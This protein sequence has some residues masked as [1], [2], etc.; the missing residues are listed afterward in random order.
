[1]AAVNDKYVVVGQPDGFTDDNVVRSRVFKKTFENFGTVNDG[2]K[3][4]L[5]TNYAVAKFPAGFVPRSI[6]VN[7]IEKDDGGASN[8]NASLA[9]YIAKN[10]TDLSDA[11]LGTSIGSVGLNAVGQTVK[12]DALTTTA[13]GSGTLTYTTTRALEPFVTSKNDY[14]VVTPSRADSGTG[15]VDAKFEVVVLGDWPELTG[16]EHL[17]KLA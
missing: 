14:L 4:A 12:G 1:M 5:G 2:D 7:V 13:S 15:D 10:V 6:V 11:T 17:P 9:L 8:K 16:I 3:L